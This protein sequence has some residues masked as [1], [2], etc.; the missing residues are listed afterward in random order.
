MVSRRKRHLQALDGL[1]DRLIEES[2]GWEST[3]DRQADVAEMSFSRIDRALM[4][5]IER[6]TPMKDNPRQSFRHLDELA[7]SI[8]DRGMI[9]PLVVR[10]DAERPGYYMTVAGARRVLAS[11][12]L[13]GSEDR[14]IRERV[15][16]LPCLVVDEADDSALASALAENLARDDLTRTE[17]MEALLRLQEQYGW[18]GR[19]IAKRT[20]RAHSDVSE[21]LRVARDKELAA[22]VRDEV[23]A[24]SAA[25]EI[26]HMDPQA[27]EQVLTGIRSGQIRTVDDVRS[28]NPRRRRQRTLAGRPVITA[29]ERLGHEAGTSEGCANSHTPLDARSDQ[30]SVEVLPEADRSGN[31]T[32]PNPSPAI[33]LGR[34]SE[35]S[36][37]SPLP[38]QDRR[39]AQLEALREHYRAIRPIVEE[40]P[41][42]AWEPEIVDERRSIETLSEKVSG[43]SKPDSMLSVEDY[44]HWLHKMSLEV[45]AFI[46]DLPN[47]ELDQRIEEGMAALRELLVPASRTSPGQVRRR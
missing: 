39:E 24:P 31:Q 9:Q 17:A 18:S 2:G 45:E 26:S 34:E 44:L 35:P 4:I 5:P 1:A 20:G 46:E 47:G 41:L 37:E 19:Q 32:T 42:L 33:G 8:A 21:L 3:P 13:R 27:R 36:K 23:I 25:G 10:R 12:L 6:I 16:E 38:P 22:L 29:G 14:E 15:A 11:N 7:D 28:A 40:R 43:H 30:E